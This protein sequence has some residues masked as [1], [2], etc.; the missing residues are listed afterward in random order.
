LRQWGRRTF[1]E[2]GEPSKRIK[3]QRGYDKGAQF[4]VQ[5]IGMLA[6]HALGCVQ[7]TTGSTRHDANK[8]AQMRPC[9]DSGHERSY[10]SIEGFEVYE[11]GI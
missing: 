10:S 11:I 6:C 4:R 2:V 9:L 5:S 8:C 1:P 7:L 3:F